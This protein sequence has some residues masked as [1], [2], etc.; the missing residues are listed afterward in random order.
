MWRSRI[1]TE[2]AEVN[3]QK[4]NL[5]FE[6]YTAIEKINFLFP[7]TIFYRSGPAKDAL[8]ET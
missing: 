1:I 3:F 7:V 5:P 4:A 8:A 2:I 6:N